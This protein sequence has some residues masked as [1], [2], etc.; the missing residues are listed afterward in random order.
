M[1]MFSVYVFLSLFLFSIFLILQFRF[2]SQWHPKQNYESHDEYGEK[3]GENPPTH[4][5]I[6]QTKA[7][8]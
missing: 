3:S 6:V 4:L 5:I 7:I 2:M 8:V 1:W